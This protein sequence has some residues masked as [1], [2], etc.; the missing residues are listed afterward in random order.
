MQKDSIPFIGLGSQ[1][2][3]S[4]SSIIGRCIFTVLA[5]FNVLLLKGPKALAAA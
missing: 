1:K 5:S 4:K 3:A 2:N